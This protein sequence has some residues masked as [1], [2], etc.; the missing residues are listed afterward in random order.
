MK[1]PIDKRGLYGI[2]H[3]TMT[4]QTFSPYIHLTAGESRAI[5]NETIRAANDAYTALGESLI[6]DIDR[7][8]AT[9]A[10]KRAHAAYLHTCANVRTLW[11][12]LLSWPRPESAASDYE[13][14]CAH[15]EDARAATLDAIRNAKH[16]P[17][18]AQPA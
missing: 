17:K 2:L 15:S 1:P 5:V 9:A 16:H 3:H 14:A 13:T 6:P 4:E 18:T 8:A 10:V 12:S 7:P 11:N